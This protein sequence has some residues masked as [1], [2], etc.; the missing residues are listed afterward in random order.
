MSAI[1][2]N[3]NSQYDVLKNLSYTLQD[4]GFIRF[5]LEIDVWVAKSPATVG[6]TLDQFYSNNE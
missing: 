2:L 4:A 3:V 6:T 1:R 5:Y